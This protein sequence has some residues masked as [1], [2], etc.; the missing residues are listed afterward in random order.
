MHPIARL[1]QAL[2]VNAVPLGGF[3]VGGWSPATTLAVYWFENVFGSL[4][5]AVRIALHRR[6]TGKRGHYQARPDQGTR[7]GARGPSG[8]RRPSHGG[9]AAVR[10]V[11]RPGDPPTFLTGFALLAFV[12]SFAQAIFLALVMWGLLRLPIEREALTSGVIGVAAF[13]LVAF[14]ADLR[15]LRSWPFAAVKEI[16]GIALG[17]VV[18]VHLSIIGGMALFAW[19]EEPRSFFGVF[20]ALKLVADL[21]SLLPRVQSDAERPPRWLGWTMSWFGEREDFERYWRETSA[22]ERTDAEEDEQVWDAARGGWCSPE[23][24]ERR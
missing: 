23:A 2:G 12:F 11:P 17:R 22:R 6:L 15:D 1:V 14:I 13:S 18:L 20:L 8:A 4:L 3:L 10:P 16:A 24:V 5:I 21:G 19:R 9:G 7:S